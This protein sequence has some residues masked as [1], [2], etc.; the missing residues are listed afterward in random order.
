MIYNWVDGLD[1][2]QAV[3]AQTVMDLRLHADEFDFIAVRGSSG[4]LV[5]APVSL[6]LDKPLVVVRKPDE[7]SH[8]RSGDVI[9]WHR[10]HGRFIFLDDMVASGRTREEVLKGLKGHRA[11]YVATYLYHPHRWRYLADEDKYD[12]GSIESVMPRSEAVAA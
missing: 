1:D 8:Q 11:S 2:M 7:K 9:N 10:A 6:A 5:G 3:V 4:M 12:R